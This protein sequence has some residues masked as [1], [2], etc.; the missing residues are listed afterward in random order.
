MKLPP[1]FLVVLT[2]AFT[3]C[4]R[5]EPKTTA[6][7]APGWDIRGEIVGVQVAKGILLVHHEEIPGFMPAM[8]MEFTAPGLDLAK[9]REGQRIT[10]RMTDR[11]ADTYQLDG[12]RVLSSPDDQAVIAAALALRQE[13]STR[14]KNVYREVGETAPTFTLY[15]QDGKATAF[16]HFRGKRVVLNFIFTRCPVA[17][18]CP[19]STAK[20][21]ALQAAAKKAGVKD[22]E[23][24]SISFDSAFDTPPVLKA[25]AEARG[26]DT[27][28]FSFLTGP[29]N[30][31]RDLLAQFGVIAE[32][33]EN[34]FKHTLS[35]L[36]IGPNGKILHR[37]DGS[38][39]APEEFLNRL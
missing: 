7:P 16:D 2:L 12:V 25:Y 35:T 36:L 13:T 28:N 6:A 39:W 27:S 24:V 19:A 37:V 22:L 11:G 9:F 32:P 3:A 20:M 30:A 15:N 23:L 1:A 34:L 26:I 10:A 5:P 18:M 29:E 33:G 31:I 21:M 17:T 14:G 4:S 38:T 8:T